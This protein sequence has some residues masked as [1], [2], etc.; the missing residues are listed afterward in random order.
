MSDFFTDLF[1]MSFPVSMCYLL[2]AD[3]FAVLGVFLGL[4]FNIWLHVKKKDD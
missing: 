4:C 2:L 1:G 3:G